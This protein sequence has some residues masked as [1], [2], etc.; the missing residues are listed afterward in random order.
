MPFVFAY[1]NA[2]GC[3]VTKAESV[4]VAAEVE[5]AV[6]DPYST[7]SC[8]SGLLTGLPTLGHSTA[9]GL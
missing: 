5:P 3:L 6:S 9:P 8:G 7:L 4:L 2:V 1:L